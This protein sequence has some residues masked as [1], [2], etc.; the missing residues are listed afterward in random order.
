MWVVGSGKLTEN[1]SELLSSYRMAE[2]FTEL[3]QMFDYIIID[4]SPIGLVA[5]AFSFKAYTDLTIYLVRYNYTKKEQLSIME[6]LFNNN[7]LTNPMIVL[8]DAKPENLKN[9]GYASSEYSYA[10]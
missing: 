10:E 2:L 9:Y 4:T 3:R 7:K 5:D 8:N 6:D 1:P